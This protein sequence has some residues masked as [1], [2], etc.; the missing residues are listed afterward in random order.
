M[1]DPQLQLA[2]HHSVTLTQQ[3]ILKASLTQ[4]TTCQPVEQTS[5]TKNLDNT[6]HCCIFMTSQ[7]QD[8]T[9][10][11]YDLQLTGQSGIQHFN[12]ASDKALRH[13]ADLHQASDTKHGS[14]A[15]H[16]GASTKNSL[17]RQVQPQQIINNWKHDTLLRMP[18]TTVISV[19]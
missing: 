4:F 17:N 8:S 7:H 6:Q 12:T 15:L 1:P 14:K 2:A 10:G 11:L 19:A 5:D 18:G 16:P 13:L 9:P 3:Q